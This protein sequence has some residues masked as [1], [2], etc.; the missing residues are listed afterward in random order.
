MMQA[1]Q[2]DREDLTEPRASLLGGLSAMFRNVH[3]AHELAAAIAVLIALGPLAT[4][5]GA[6]LLTRQDRSEAERLRTE[7]APRLAAERSIEAARSEI[8]ALVRRP[9]IGT[10][11]EAFARGLP[12]DA[13]VIRIERNANGGLEADIIAAD[14][15]QLR[16]AIRR[17]PALAQM[18][19]TSQR[20]SDTAM[21]VTLRQ[22][23]P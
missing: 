19:N 13:T 22:D 3:P 23:A 9:A 15:D 21:I 14:P 12:A 20:Q 8:G 10:T 4:I 2:P 6:Q 16:A 1:G 17:D 18:R 5:A 7:L 11:L